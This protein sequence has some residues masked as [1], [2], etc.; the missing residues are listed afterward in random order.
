MLLFRQCGWLIALLM[1]S[2]ACYGFNQEDFPE[3]NKE[4]KLKAAYLFNFTK[5]I[6]WPAMKQGEPRKNICICLQQQGEFHHFLSELVDGRKVG[7][8]NFPVLVLNIGPDQHCDIAFLDNVNEADIT[9]LQ[10]TLVITDEEDAAMA[11]SG[12]RF[13]RENARLLKT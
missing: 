1:L 13:Y 4:Q 6:D 5:F 9:L 10:D 7:Q 3:L 12:I 8:H 11:V 2:C